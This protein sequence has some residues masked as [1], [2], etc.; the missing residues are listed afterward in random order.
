[1]IFNGGDAYPMSGYMLRIDGDSVRVS[2]RQDAKSTYFASTQ[3]TIENNKYFYVVVTC[4]GKTASLYIDGVLD[5]QF[6]IVDS[7]PATTPFTISAAS[8]SFLGLMDDLAVY[9]RA[10]STEEVIKSYQQGAA[11]HG[12]DASWI[13]KIRLTPYCHYDQGTV[14]IEADFAGVLPLQADQEASFVLGQPDKASAQ[15]HV[16][17]EMPQTGRYEC[18]L[19]LKDLPDGKYEIAAV[20]KD[21]T[22]RVVKQSAV[23]LSVPYEPVKVAAPSEKTVAL[24][25]KPPEPA[26]YQFNLNPDGGF[27]FSVA[28]ENY[29]VESAFSWPNGERA[30]LESF[31]AQS[32]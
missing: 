32:G 31:Y 22:G 21:A 14:T 7:A 2:Y 3:G 16:I 12:K 30:G 4:E 25:P 5:K 15:V 6:P 28:G 29:P 18:D 24:L 10:L 27:Q 9:H 19:P 26:A 20:V 11:D 17:K 1:V 8:Q 23:T 13:G